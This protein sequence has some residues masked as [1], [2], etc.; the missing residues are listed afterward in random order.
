MF[1]LLRHIRESLD[2]SL[3]LRLPKVSLTLRNT[4][5]RIQAEG[6]PTYE[7]GAKTSEVLELSLD[8]EVISFQIAD[9]IDIKDGRRHFEKINI[10]TLLFLLRKQGS[11]NYRC[12]E[13]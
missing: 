4:E 5:E 2:R 13:G 9:T 10:G 6:G 3:G 1:S 8:G 11:A 7:R 12:R